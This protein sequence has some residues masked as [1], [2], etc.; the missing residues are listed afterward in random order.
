MDSPTLTRTF[1]PTGFTVAADF[2]EG[3]TVEMEQ[4]GESV[5]IGPLNEMQMDDLAMLQLLAG[6]PLTQFTV[7]VTITLEDQ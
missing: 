4:H 1:Y 3:V 7:A 2:F 6:E 5:R